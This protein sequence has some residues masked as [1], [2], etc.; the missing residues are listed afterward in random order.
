ML[1][2]F[3]VRRSRGLPGSLLSDHGQLHLLSLVFDLLGLLG[4]SVLALQVDI[5]LGKLHNRGETLVLIVLV[6]VHAV[7]QHF[8]EVANFNGEVGREVLA[9]NL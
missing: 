7:G 6:E 2:W 1:L 4:D 5:G 9:V 3:F 8:F